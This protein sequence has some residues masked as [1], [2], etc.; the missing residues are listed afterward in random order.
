MRK[1]YHHG[2]LRGA[3]IAETVSMIEAD[4]THLIGFRELARR[5]E[6]S[7]TA[8][9]RHFET[10]DILLSVVAE[11]GYRKFVEYLERVT[12]EPDLEDG[13]RFIQLGEAY[14]NF[15]LDNPAHYRL[16]FDQRFFEGDKYA[17]VQG[18][19]MRAFELLRVT[20]S[21]CLKAESTTSDKILLANIAW[22]S[23]HGLSALLMNGQIRGVK[24]RKQFVRK[25]CER[26]LKIADF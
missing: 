25:S 1:S 5:L 4:E 6:V 22:A 3:L 15:A 18:L 9:Y 23:V 7:R 8:P 10:V 2:D 13:E 20:S 14:I 19:A 26:L 17:V 11:D 24:N 12:A 16:L 21:R